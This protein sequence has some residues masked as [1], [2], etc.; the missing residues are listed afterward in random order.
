M[1]QKRK[2]FEANFNMKSRGFSRLFHLPKVSQKIEYLLA[3]PIREEF[4]VTAKSKDSRL[5]ISNYISFTHM[6]LSV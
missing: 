2:A 3:V 1:H 6:I 5:S 4:V